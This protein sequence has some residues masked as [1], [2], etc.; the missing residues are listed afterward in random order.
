MKV[1]TIGETSILTVF[2]CPPIPVRSFDWS[3]CET[4]ADEDSPIGWGR[5]ADES[6]ADL[7]Q[8]IKEARD[9]RV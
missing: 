9:D 6:I 3:A 2:V 4:D 5:T 1:V 8:Q 7:L